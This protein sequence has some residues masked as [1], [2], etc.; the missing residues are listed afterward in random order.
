MRLQ[1]AKVRVGLQ[2]RVAL[3]DYEKPLQGRTQRGLGLLVL[4]ELRRIGRRRGRADLR[5][6]DRRAG[7]HHGFERGLLKLR[8][9]L[10]G[11]DQVGDEVG[12]ALVL[13]LDLRPLLV[14]LLPQRDEAI[15]GSGERD[16]DDENQDD[17]NGDTPQPDFSHASPPCCRERDSIRNPKSKIQKP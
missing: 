3:D 4:R 16:P 5:A 8:G 11:R 14:R 2:L 10:D 15:V 6:A 12:P 9:A 7:L 17:E 1:I 13:I